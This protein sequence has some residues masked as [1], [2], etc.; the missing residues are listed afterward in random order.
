MMGHKEQMKGGDEYD[1]LT[2]WK[3]FLSFKPGAR[4][5]VKRGFNKRVR[6]EAKQEVA[7]WV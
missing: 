6:R 2:G 5:K 1:S 4:K 3:E 7:Q